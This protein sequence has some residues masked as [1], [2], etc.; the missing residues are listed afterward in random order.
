MRKL[1]YVLFAVGMIGL[2]I[3]LNFDTSVPVE[4][5]DGRRINNLGMMNDRLTILLV[6]G[7]L[8]VV[9]AIFIAVGSTTPAPA[10]SADVDLRP[11]PSCAE[12]IRAAAIVCRYCGRDVI[13]DAVH[14]QLPMAVA[15][16]NLEEVGLSVPECL[17]HLRALGYG[18]TS[19]LGWAW[20]VHAPD[21]KSELIAW[22]LSE[23]RG[24]V[25]DTERQASKRP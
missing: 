11:C 9:G 7:S 1:G 2:V 5:L 14:A 19:W 10:A 13:S 22:S 21:R 20:S 4:L 15:A 6:S 17:A 16:A 12:P 24:I 23:L 3:G 25:A 8:A 18:T